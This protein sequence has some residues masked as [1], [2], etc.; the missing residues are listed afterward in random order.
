MPHLVPLDR[1]ILETMYVRVAAGH[2]RAQVA[3]ALQAAYAR[4]PSCA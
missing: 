4:R 3:D 2:D 1:G